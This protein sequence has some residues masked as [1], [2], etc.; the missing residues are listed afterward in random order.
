MRKKDGFTLVE[1]IVVIAILAILAGVA[2][3][4]Y[5]GYIKKA[6]QAADLMLLDAVNT[7]LQVAYME[8]GE[9]KPDTGL[10]L[11]G[12]GKTVQ[13]IDHASDAVKGSFDKFFAGNAG[14][15]LKSCDS[16]SDVL[17]E[18]GFFKL[19]GMSGSS[20]THTFEYGGKTYTYSQE[21]L[22]RFNASPSF[23]AAD[24]SELTGTVDMLSGALSDSKGGLAALVNNSPSF[25]AMLESLGVITEGQVVNN[26]MSSALAD[27]IANASV[28]YIASNA[29]NL[30]ASQIYEKIKNGEDVGS[31]LTS[32]GFEAGVNT[33][34]V[35]TAIKFALATAFV[36]SDYGGDYIDLYNA[37]K[38][39]ITN[40][41]TA[42]E[43]YSLFSDLDEFQDYLSDPDYA[44]K[45][46]EGFLGALSVINENAANFDL[47]GNYS[48]YNDVI[49][50]I[51]H[52]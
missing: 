27:E 41:S 48:V 23:S 18:G 46:I 24:I 20:T 29:G 1:L 3:P 47:S 43:F 28:L 36:N 17:Y 38:G 8:Q 33:T 15:E 45:D 44:E 10:S 34:F 50:S 5:S 26:S 40:L 30:E 14:T 42:A 13:S 21:D 49:N 35:N 25:R 31:M 16:V 11:A 52:P 12:S 51:L 39:T 2:I 19:P 9:T 4:A 37:R 6:N 32:A 7:A 22:D